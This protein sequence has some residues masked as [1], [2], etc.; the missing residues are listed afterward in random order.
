MN[1]T[2]LAEDQGD[3]VLFTVLEDGTEDVT[4]EVVKFPATR[5]AAYV[6][7]YDNGAIEVGVRYPDGATPPPT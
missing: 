4:Q 2:V 6:T 1:R 5:W 3:R 7:L